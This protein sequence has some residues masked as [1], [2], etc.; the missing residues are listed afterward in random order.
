MK[1]ASEPPSPIAR[2]RSLLR[3]GPLPIALRFVDQIYRLVSGAPLWR[4]SAVTPQLSLG[5]QH[6]PRGC[7]RMR[8]FGISAV[9]N[10][11]EARFNDVAQGIGGAGRLHLP[12]IDNTPPSLADLCAGVAFA[13]AEIARGGKVYIHCGV[14]VGRAPTMLAACLIADG[15]TPADA[16]NSI[17]AVRPFIHLTAGQSQALEDFAAFQAAR[18]GDDRCPG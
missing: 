17:K 1:A 10:M 14:G 9:V 11:R 2:A 3:T 16:L 12:T 18:R 7:A 4:L 15:S 6:Y 5:G 13:Q 8:D